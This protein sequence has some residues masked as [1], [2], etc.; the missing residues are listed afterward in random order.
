MNFR[1]FP[2]APPLFN[3]TTI[4]SAIGR[5]QGKP[6]R[7]NVFSL[8]LQ[9]EHRGGM[10]PLLPFL[11]SP[12][13]LFVCFACFVVSSP[14][15]ASP[16]Y[17]YKIVAKS[18]DTIDG[19]PVQS[20]KR[21]VSIND[22]NRV[23]F[24]AEGAGGSE[25]VF[26]A[27]LDN[28]TPVFHKLV[29][30]TVGDFG[31]VSLNNK[32]KVAVNFRAVGAG[33]TS[34]NVRR[35]GPTGLG[36][37]ISYASADIA[38]GTTARRTVTINPCLPFG[39]CPF[40]KR[41]R[42]EAF[43][44]ILGPVSLNDSDQV[45]YLGLVIQDSGQRSYHFTVQDHYPVPKTTDAFSITPYQTFSLLP[46]FRPVLANSGHIVARVGGQPNSPILLYSPGFASPVQAV[47]GAASFTRIGQ[48][49]G[50]SD[51]G[52]VV[53]FV[54]DRGNGP[55][56]F[57]S[58]TNP[59]NP[60]GPR[61]ILRLAGENASANGPTAE[62]GYDANTNKLY[63]DSFDADAKVGV[64][65]FPQGDPVDGIAEDSITVC[66]SAT[67]NA[68]GSGSNAFSANKGLWAIRVDVDRALQPVVSGLY[69]VVQLG[70][71]LPGL[72]DTVTD[73]ALSDPIAVV[74]TDDGGNAIAPD[75][76]AHRCHFAG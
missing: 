45:A 69:P 10:A 1:A 36:G 30:K 65:H 25:A 4:K 74:A 54:G 58:I 38:Q 67:P 18:G 41:F 11:L 68:P 29:E 2:I 47:A 17:D 13:L 19:F 63:F 5:P 23:A 70:D 72:T 28:A 56:L 40:T 9:G 3:R 48:A 31:S 37:G 21:L 43:D 22:S 52:M 76:C 61:M 53:A 8:R 71:P 73:F 27:N 60:S 39:D 16:F 20:F 66:F 44:D 15:S 34:A 14:A 26:I 24:I 64:V 50:L 42:D 6:H 57:L 75:S 7:R 55:G 33:I 49:P 46:E 32:N 62:L 59:A 35:Y 51:N 12:L